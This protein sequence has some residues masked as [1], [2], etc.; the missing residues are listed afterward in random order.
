[1]IR[2]YFSILKRGEIDVGNGIKGRVCRKKEGNDRAV[3]F[4]ES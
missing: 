2:A 4:D 3:E 1:M